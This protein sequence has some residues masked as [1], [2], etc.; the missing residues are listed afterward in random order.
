MQAR[1][2]GEVH[3]Q[4]CEATFLHQHR[5]GSLFH[6]YLEQPVGSDMLYEATMQ[7]IVECLNRTR[8]DLCR[9]GNLKHP[10][11]GKHLRKGTQIFSSS[12]IMSR[13]LEQL[14]CPRNH[15]QVAGS[16][17]TS[18]GHRLMVSEYTELYSR[19]FGKNL[20]RAM[21]ASRMPDE[22]ALRCPLVMFNNCFVEPA[23]TTDA[24]PDVKRR[25][26]SA[27]TTNP[28]GYPEAAVPPNTHAWINEPNLPSKES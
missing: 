11:S 19:T 23:M 1:E 8:C 18:D 21:K 17:R 6:F 25:R 5:M 4:L 28:V 27:K 20:A 15:A 14:T 13:S 16:F 3:L 12:M 24:E 26:L 10:T 2:S 7:T 22:K 9:V